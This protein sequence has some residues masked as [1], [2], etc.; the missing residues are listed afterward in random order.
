MRFLEKVFCYSP[1][2]HA[3]THS[4]CTH[5]DIHTDARTVTSDSKVTCC[6]NCLDLL[7]DS[8]LV[9]NASP[10]VALL[11]CYSNYGKAFLIYP[12]TFFCNYIITLLFFVC[13]ALATD[14]HLYGRAPIFSLTHSPDP[15]IFFFS[16][17]YPHSLSPFFS[18]L[19][20]ILLSQFHFA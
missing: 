15:L 10:K 4:A 18:L 5:T 7:L 19:L 11:S 6:S 9:L 14:S 20:S 3:Q 1:D 17:I 8:A 2:S 16:T 12:L 13:K